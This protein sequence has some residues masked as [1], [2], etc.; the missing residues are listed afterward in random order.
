MMK[1][2]HQPTDAVGALEAA[3][4]SG[5]GQRSSPPHRHQ[6]FGHSV[7]GLLFLLGQGTQ[8]ILLTLG[9]EG[10]AS[11]FLL[12]DGFPVS[13]LT[14]WAMSARM[15]G[16]CPFSTRVVQRRTARQA[17]F[18]TGSRTCSKRSE[19]S[20][21]VGTGCPN[22]PASNVEG[23]PHPCISFLPEDITTWSQMAKLIGSRLGGQSRVSSFPSLMTR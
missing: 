1:A 4:A 8:R 22:A 12:S 2:P 6:G 16:Y 7:Q 13:F 11:F 15:H 23:F 9:Y 17:R 10:A 20:T 18:P 21:D 19:G 14:G 3:H 5:Y